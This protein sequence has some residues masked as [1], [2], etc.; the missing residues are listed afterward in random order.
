MELTCLLLA[1]FLIQAPT[2]AAKPEAKGPA[3]FKVDYIGGQPMPAKLTPGTLTFE[4]GAVTFKGGGAQIGVPFGEV[5]KLRYGRIALK[6]VD[7]AQLVPEARGGALR[8][9]TLL[10]VQ[11]THKDTTSHLLLRL[12]AKE[13]QQI[14]TQVETKTAKKA[15]RSKPDGAGKGGAKA[16]GGAQEKPASSGQ[17]NQTKKP[18]QTQPKS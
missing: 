11:F 13:A 6:G 4:N 5:T 9:R 10:D 15:D 18:A 3:E 2:T 8:K 1:A 7:K 16:K 14:L 17:P 12:P